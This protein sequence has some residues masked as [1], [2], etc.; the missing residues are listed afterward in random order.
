MDLTNLTS[1]SNG[2]GK[3]KEADPAP[4]R[5]SGVSAGSH[6]DSLEAFRLNPN[7]KWKA[8]TLAAF[9]DMTA[10]SLFNSPIIVKTQEKFY[11]GNDDVWRALEH[12]AEDRHWLHDFVINNAT[13]MEP[14]WLEQPIKI[15]F[16][17]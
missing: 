9:K 4:L 7:G 15:L 11:C 10:S 5:S 12:K 17:I 14:G 3:R 6:L 1:Q 8:M 16:A 2:C 13:N